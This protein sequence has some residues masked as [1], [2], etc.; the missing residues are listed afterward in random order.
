MFWACFGHV[1]GMFL[2]MFES[3]KKPLKK[4]EFYAEFQS[5]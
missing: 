4:G 1:L 3:L 2:A 5:V